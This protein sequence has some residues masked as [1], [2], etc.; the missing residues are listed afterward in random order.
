[1][2]QCPQCKSTFEDSQTY[3]LIDGSLLETYIEPD[4]KKNGS[5]KAKYIALLLIVLLLLGGILFIFL[6][7]GLRNYDSNKNI[8]NTTNTQP[9]AATPSPSVNL[10]PSPSA[11]VTNTS[12][13]A[14]MNTNVN[15]ASNQNADPGANSTPATAVVGMKAEDHSV[16]FNLQNC[17]RSGSS[18]TCDLLITNKGTD[19][20]F[21]LL[22]YNSVLYDELGNG[23]RGSEAK[24]ANQTG[25]S[26]EIGFINNVTAKGQLVFEKI[27]AN[28]SK[29]TLLNV[30]FSVGND[31]DL[32]VKF[33][34]VPLN[35]DK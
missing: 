27:E 6:W 25:N 4:E 9:S 3:C 20:K 24:V 2:K 13:N 14:E 10:T 18:I 30:A 1:M 23:Y 21:W 8:S 7:V 12:V 22:S 5:G 33:R 19:R 17:R 16:L 26:P 34:N 31:Y 32:S 35:V 28:S 15:V 11:T 29:I